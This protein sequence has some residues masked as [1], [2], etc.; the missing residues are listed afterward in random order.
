V[1]ECL[2]PRECTNS[3]IPSPVALATAVLF[4]YR[5]PPSLYRRNRI[6]AVHEP[7]PVLSYGTALVPY[8]GASDHLQR[9]DR[10]EAN[11]E[12]LLL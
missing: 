12:I 8:A 3:P 10:L 11:P 7:N 6:P 9:R 1:G 2:S 4:D 5:K